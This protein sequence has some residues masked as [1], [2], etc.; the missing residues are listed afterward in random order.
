MEV[1]RSANM[2]H[3]P[4]AEMPELDL[5]CCCVAEADGRVVGVGGY[6][7]LSGTEAKTTLLAVLPAYRGWGVGYALQ[8]WRM[9]ELHEKGIRRLTTNAD[10]PETIAWYIKHFGYRE[11]GSLAKV[12]EFGHPDIPR[13]TTLQV[14]LDEWR[15][16]HDRQPG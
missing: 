4:S 8:V 14:D 10:R 16:T 7:I 9:H 2:H 1:L 3:V 15:T 13:W 12:H 5:A 11:T 6:R